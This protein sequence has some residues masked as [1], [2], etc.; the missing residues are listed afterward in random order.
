[1]EETIL[2]SEVEEEEDGLKSSALFVRE[3]T[4]PPKMDRMDSLS[5]PPG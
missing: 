1:V 5:L 4:N 2:I 3:R